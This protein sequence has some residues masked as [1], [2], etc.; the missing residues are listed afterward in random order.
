[1]GE[2]QEPGP[3]W[4]SVCVPARCVLPVPG[5]CWAVGASAKREVTGP[6]QHA[7]RALERQ[8]LVD[9]ADAIRRG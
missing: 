3:G 8:T 5:A 2:G 1:M 4:G 9:R 7:G 6:G